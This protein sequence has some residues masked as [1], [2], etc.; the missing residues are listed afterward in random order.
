ML[1]IKVQCDCGQRFKFDVEPL[2]GRMPYAVNCPLCGL[3]G[4]EKA[5]ATLSQVLGAPVSTHAVAAFPPIGA[6]VQVAPA[7]A[8]A[9]ASLVP[10]APPPPSSSAPRLRINKESALAPEPA[11]AVATAAPTAPTGYVN[12]L[13][14]RAQNQAAAAQQTP[15]KKPSFALGLL[16]AFI[17]AAVGSTIYFLIFNY[18]GIRLKLLAIGVGYLTGLGAELL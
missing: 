1:E 18:T 15:G 3:D 12:P 13:Q 11:P 5:N 17:G 14:Q 8:G 9:P 6:P 7:F 2:N 4:T 16:G 10:Q